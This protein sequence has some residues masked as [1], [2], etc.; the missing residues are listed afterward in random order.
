MKE[1][2]AKERDRETSFSGEKPCLP[3][4][5][6]L[7][8]SNRKKKKLSKKKATFKKNKRETP[9]KQLKSKQRKIQKTSEI[10]FRQSL[11]ARFWYNS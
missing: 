7:R 5:S 9:T 8:A 1:K 3:S 10:T 4:A 6:E 11:V 2:T